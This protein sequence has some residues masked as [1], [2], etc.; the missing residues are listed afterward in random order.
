MKKRVFGRQ[1]SQATK[2]RKAL[3]RSLVKALVIN[4]KIKTTKAKAKAVQ[5]MVDKIINLAKD[6]SLS[7]KRK[8]Y[9]LLGNDRK[10]SNQIFEIVKTGFSERNSGYTRVVNLPE[11][12][13][14][15]SPMVRLEWTEEIGI[16]EKG[17]SDKSKKKV[18]EKSKSKK[19]KK[20]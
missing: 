17:K 13:G 16:K 7:K 2:S 10:I 20:D 12:R 9:A 8:V 15:L 5:G 19:Q 4:G 18:E 1:L 11:R 3:F 14:D 6:G